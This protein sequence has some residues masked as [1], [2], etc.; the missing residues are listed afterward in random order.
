MQNHQNLTLEFQMLMDW[1]YKS[2]FQMAL[3][4]HFVVENKEDRVLVNFMGFEVTRAHRNM[5]PAFAA[6]SLGATTETLSEIIHH[7]GI[8]VSQITGLSVGDSGNKTSTANDL[9]QW[10]LIHRLSQAYFDHPQR[11]LNFEVNASSFFESAESQVAALLLPVDALWPVNKISQYLEERSANPEQFESTPWKVH[12]RSFETGRLDLRDFDHDQ[13]I[14]MIER[15]GNLI[16]EDDSEHWYSNDFFITVLQALAFSGAKNHH[17]MCEA[18][19]AV[20]DPDMLEKLN[21]KIIYELSLCDFQTSIQAINMLVAIEK[22]MPKDKFGA[23]S[24]NIMVNI[25][26]LEFVEAGGNPS[27]SSEYDHSYRVAWRLKRQETLEALCQDLMRLEPQEFKAQHF[28]ALHKVS[29]GFLPAHSVSNIDLNSLLAHVLNG[30][31]AYR[32]RGG[33]AKARDEWTERSEDRLQTFVE[34]VN[35]RCQPDYEMMN[36]LPSYTQ[37]MLV[38]KGYDVLRMKGLNRRD[39]GRVL[40]DGLGL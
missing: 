17:K 6:V 4:D 9:S 23:I 25:N 12:P 13:I 2:D 20:Q 10:N 15:S 22:G 3:A 1:Y 18:I 11:A 39:R 38:K 5:I 28:K 21:R 31:E 8:T 30:F 24:K 40:E 26:L 16:P 14:T 37:S 36:Q 27:F 29:D 34:L 33:N 32:N 19:C 35:S 7:H